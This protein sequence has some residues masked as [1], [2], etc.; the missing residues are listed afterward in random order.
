MWCECVVRMGCSYRLISGY[1]QG[2]L[3]VLHLQ[4]AEGKSPA[5]LSW[6]PSL[7]CLGSSFSF[8]IC[9]GRSW[10]VTRLL[11]HR[12]PPWLLH[13][14]SSL[15]TV[16]FPQWLMWN[17]TW[18]MSPALLADG[19]SVVNK[20]PVLAPGKLLDL[21]RSH[22]SHSLYAA[23]HRAEW[24]HLFLHHHLTSPTAAQHS[25]DSTGLCLCLG[26][27]YRREG[28]TSR[29]RLVIPGDIPPG[30]AQVPFQPC[31][32]HAALQHR[33][34]LILCIAL[35]SFRCSGLSGLMLPFQSW[36][37]FAA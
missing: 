16:W 18:T 28:E 5:L 26:S 34:A 37:P 10:L 32:K 36:S 6:A 27:A 25:S 33:C 23:V 3:P 14:L 15:I 1:V 7:R 22:S 9:S 4:G 31:Q 11:H 20:D 13:C 35:C 17:C 24:K 29:E 21:K 30:S 19:N 12:L 2:S 8:S